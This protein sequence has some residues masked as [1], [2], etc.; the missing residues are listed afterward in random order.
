MV[1]STMASDP[2][3]DDPETLL[4]HAAWLRGL[5]RSLVGETAL[6]DDVVQDTWVAALRRPP[7]ADRPLRP[8]L[9]TVLTNVVRFRWRSEANRAAREHAA[10]AL[11]EV[12]V[13]SSEQLLER[14]E[15]Q[16]LLARFVTELDEPYRAAI[17]LRYAEGLA[18]SDI[19][20][21]LG[22]PAG[23]VR[24]RLNEALARLRARLDALHRGDRRAWMAALA[25]LTRGL[26]MTTTK[27]SPWIVLAL[28][29][30]AILITAWGVRRAL[31]PRPSTDATQAGARGFAP[32]PAPKPRDDVV[33]ELARSRP[34]GWIAQEGA[35][36]R[37]VAGRV[38]VDG[39]PAAGVIVRLTSE[40]SLAGI[41]PVIEQRTMAAGTFD[42]GAQVAREL[43]V[44]AAVPG[45]LAA[46][47][48]VDLRDPT[49]RPAPDAI[50][51]V[52]GA[53]LAAFYGTVTDASGAPIAHAQLLREDAIGTTADAAGAYELCV[54]PVAVANEQLQL[55][56]R[57]DGYG[58]VMIEAGLSG[59]VHHDFVLGPEATVTGRAVTRDGQPVAH[60]KIWIERDDADR[61][62]ETETTARLLAATDEAGGFRIAGLSGGRHRIGGAAAGMTA[63]PV[64][65]V[66]AAGG[67]RDV[68]LV[69]EATGVV[70]GRVVRGGEPVAG[71]RVTVS[72]GASD[73]AVSQVDGTFVLDRV[74][75]GDVRFTAGPYRVRSPATAAVAAGT[76]NDVV[77]EVEPLGLLRGTVRRHGVP[78]PGA[79]VCAARRRPP[80]TCGVADPLGRYELGGLEPGDYAVF[81][82]DTQ[83]G[84]F[85]HDVKLTLALGEHRELE[86]ELAGG[87][88][89]TG[90]VSDRGGVSAA[91]VHVRFARR[92]AMD[93]GRCVSDAGGRFD[94]ASMAGGGAYEVAVFAGPDAAVAFP[95][96]GAAPAAFDLAD[97]D[98]RI[99]GVRL[100]IDAGRRAI[101]G[102][103]V[104]ATGAPVS[105]ARVHAWGD[106]AEP[107]WLVPVPAAATDSD[108][109]FRIGELA[110]GRYTL[111]V[112]TTD[113]ARQLRR[114]IAAGQDVRLVVDTAL[115]RN[116]ALSGSAEPPR[117]TIVP[118]EPG[119]IPYRP[120]GR[121]VWDDRIELV[122]WNLPR[123]VGRGADIEVT[124]YY[125]VV[126]PLDGA[127]KIFLHLAGPGWLNA[128]HEPADGQC[129]T[130]IWKPGD[131]VVDR[132]TTRLPTDKR[133]GTYDVRIGFFTGWA[134]SWRNLPI[135]EAPAE[136]RHA[137]DGLQLTTIVVE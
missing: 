55:V 54:L 70:H 31:A 4:A 3:D 105:D 83:V 60:A 9:R 30:I 18:P 7:D 41:V 120:R 10:E 109:A 134:P 32:A 59:R 92:G 2:A 17:L 114:G 110:P 6:A 118:D 81:A 46:I 11:T 58:A 12:A 89:I 76:R 42:F 133:P 74:P 28:A 71:A 25:P 132:F 21:R 111:E 35:P 52:P 67:S 107:D 104:D 96:V 125:K 94:C 27:I 16:R 87:A 47:Q 128:D 73:E 123:T 19:A 86:L 82:D 135:S 15:A 43:T 63:S 85:V 51:L 116:P 20:R 37:R 136:L 115:C 1:G 90:T 61:R 38:V 131:V 45:R 24:W 95:F 108:G 72:G 102:T 57:A 49:G 62:R 113:G 99:D 23:T 44:S 29:L 106:G 127:W 50:E 68:A 126:R 79:R 66:V 36:M 40:L 91:G 8:W 5:A 84:A 39:V 14:H 26:A 22:V 88:R 77:L 13:P 121:V 122:G 112:R 64:T 101:R 129:P 80:N 75:V 119:D 69:M 93:E 97:G 103:I 117:T 53:C 56:V 98:A 34:P 78:V 48:H 100:V 65:L 130:S 137:S 33:S 124:L